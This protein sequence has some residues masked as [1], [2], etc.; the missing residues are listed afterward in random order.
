[1]RGAK[2]RGPGGSHLLMTRDH[3]GNVVAASIRTS[4]R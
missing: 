2:K 3:A 4:G 1:M